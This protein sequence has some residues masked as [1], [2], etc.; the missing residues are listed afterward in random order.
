MK[1]KMKYL[2]QIISMI[3]VV[4]SCSSDD[5][6]E[7][8]QNP[9]PPTSKTETFT[10][11][12]DGE[13][14]NGKIY[15][16]ADYQ[17]NKNLPAIF[18]IDFTE[19]HFTVA[20]DE[21]EKVIEGVEQIEDFDALVITLEEHLNVDSNPSDFQEYYDLYKSMAMYVGQNY[22]ENTSRTFIGRG[23]EGGLVLMALFLED[24]ETSLFDN[25]I[26]TDS[27]TA[28]NSNIVNML[29]NNN[30]PQNKQN[31]KL[32]FSFSTSNSFNSCTQLINTINE[33]QYPW[34]QF[35]SK[36]Y[37]T[38]TFVSTYPV[39]FTEGLNYIFNE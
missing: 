15:L 31:K 22:T 2:L 21:F 9:D 35:E 27:P 11:S 37:T 23:S 7:P 32:H 18:L 26:A 13:D 38:S 6:T 10:F 25:F 17:A 20:K 36:H 34:L 28:F 14:V 24:P 16:P 39:S 29:A 1:F 5:T 8:I 4:A 3:L 33:A 19:Q 12:S 30:F